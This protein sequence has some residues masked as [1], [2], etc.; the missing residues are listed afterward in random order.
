VKRTTRA[1]REPREYSLRKIA[2]NTPV[3]T[4][5]SVPMPTMISVPTSALP[6]P[7]PVRPSAGGSD[8]SIARW[9][10]TAPCTSTM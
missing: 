2:V 3:G 4:A 10:W 8:Q 5:T 9:K 1:L 7:P 6:K